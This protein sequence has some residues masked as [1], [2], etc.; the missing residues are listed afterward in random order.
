[1]IKLIAFKADNP[2]MGKTYCSIEICKILTAAG[3]NTVRFSFAGCLKGIAAKSLHT[4]G[5]LGTPDVTYLDSVKEDY[6]VYSPNTYRD[7]LI[8]LA[9]EIRQVDPE[10][11]TKPLVKLCNDLEPN[12]VI[13]VDD[14]R[15]P[16]EYAIIREL[17][18]V[19]IHIKGTERKSTLATNSMEG[20]LNNHI[21]DHSLIND[22]TQPQLTHQALKDTVRHLFKV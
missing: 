11:F 15:T 22:K 1:M 20:L 18:G 4:A 3:V 10:F 5:L 12:T 13:V 21:S 9:T 2:G 19:V 6:I 17:E 8:T 7:Y 14:L 16:L